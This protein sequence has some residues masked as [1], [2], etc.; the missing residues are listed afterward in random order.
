MKKSILVGCIFASII[1]GITIG[2]IAHIYSD[3]TLEKASLREIEKV[4]ELIKQENVIATANN[5]EKSSPNCEIIFE[6]HYNECG[7]TEIEHKVIESN[8]VNKDEEYFK[9][10]YNEWKVKSFKPDEINLYKEIN[11]ICKK[12]YIIKEKDGYI[13]VY[14]IDLGGNQEL[15]EVTDIYTKYLPEE[16]IKL[17]E[18]GIMANGDNELREKLGDFE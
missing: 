5:K 3:N 11:G 13:A 15:K 17:L 6:T 8:D 1:T 16:D 14:T 4:N 7:H 2:M 12:H 10:K 18:K 9:N